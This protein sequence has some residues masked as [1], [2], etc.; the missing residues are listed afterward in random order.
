MAVSQ[1]QYRPNC[2][3]F[4]PA[5]TQGLRSRRQEAQDDVRADEFLRRFLFHVL[6]RGFV[7]IRHFGFLTNR[8]RAR[9]IATCR[10]LLS[11]SPLASR[12]AQ[13]PRQWSCPNC[14]AAMV[15]VEK[16][17]PRDIRFCAIRL[18]GAPTPPRRFRSP[19][20]CAF[21][22]EQDWCGRATLR[23]REAAP[24]APVAHLKLASVAPSV[25]AEMLFADLSPSE[26]AAPRCQSPKQ[27][28]YA[29]RAASHRRCPV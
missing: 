19:G 22:R 27:I 16:L 9:L 17:T 21:R 24:L 3:C 18:D 5:M 4:I 28:P 11:D 12:V 15:V 1:L 20:P 29:R 10:R 2:G 13:P 6:P 23:Q 26:I 7:R 25:D 14:R 8:S